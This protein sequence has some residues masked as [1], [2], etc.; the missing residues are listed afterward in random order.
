M[1]LK[2]LHTLNFEDNDIYRIESYQDKII[3]NED[4]HGIRILDFSLNTI[5]VYNEP[6]NSDQWLRSKFASK[7]VNRKGQKWQEKNLVPNLKLRW[8]WNS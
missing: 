8:H 7:L 1:I 2:R 3:A 5:K 4:Y 6:I